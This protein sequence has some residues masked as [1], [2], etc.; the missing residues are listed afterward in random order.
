MRGLLRDEVTDFDGRWFQLRD[1]RCEP[2]PVQAELPIWVGGQGERRT[3]RIAA[4]WADGWNVPF[5]A[6]E[7]FAHK[8]ERPPR[9]LR[10]RRPRPRRAPHRGQPRPGLDGGEPPAAVRRPGRLRPPGRADGLRGGGAR[11]HRAVRRRRR[12]PGEPGPAGAVRHRRCSI[13]SPPRWV[14]PDPDRVGAVAG[15]G[16]WAMQGAAGDGGQRCVL[17][18]CDPPRRGAGTASVTSR[19]SDASRPASNVEGGRRR[20]PPRTTGG[21]RAIPWPSH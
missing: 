6:P 4:R 19:L 3:L 7:T 10:R 17:D 5:V 20:T 13:A 16:G 21:R 18:L 14:Y 2:R 1:A 9:P 11:P 12:R 8:R 15:G